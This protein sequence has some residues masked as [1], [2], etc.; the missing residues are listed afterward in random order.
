MTLSFRED[1]FVITHDANS[2]FTYYGFIFTF[3]VLSSLNMKYTSHV[4][5]LC[6]DYE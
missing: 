2:D 1:A 5:V 6:L 3:K 4:I